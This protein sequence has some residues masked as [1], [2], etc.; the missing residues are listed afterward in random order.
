MS[1]ESGTAWRGSTRREKRRSDENGACLALIV[2]SRLRSFVAENRHQEW[3]AA[4][5]LL[6]RV[7]NPAPEAANFKSFQRLIGG[8]RRS[9]LEPLSA[10]EENRWFSYESFLE[11]L[12]TVGIN[13]E[14]SGGLYALHAHL[15]HSCE[16]NLQVS[17]ARR[18]CAEPKKV[19]NLPKSFAPPDPSALPCDLPSPNPSGVRGTNRLTL[20]A[21]RTIQ[22]GEELCISY[23]NFALTR[24]ERRQALREEYGFWCSCPKCLREKKTDEQVVTQG[25]DFAQV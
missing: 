19:R 12:G 11:L 1:R 3:R 21:R 18:M 17:L 13:Q 4:L 5:D 10:E 16:P 20:L 15:N 6:T 9:R 7:L 22:P 23:V 24:A 25:A 2:R 14:A 8:S